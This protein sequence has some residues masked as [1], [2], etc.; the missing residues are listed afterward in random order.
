MTWWSLCAFNGVGSVD[1][2]ALLSPVLAPPLSAV[3]MS[4]EWHLVG[5]SAMD[6]KHYKTLQQT[7]D[8]IVF[9]Q[10]SFW[11]SNELLAVKRLC[12]ENVRVLGLQPTISDDPPPEEVL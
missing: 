8:E 5:Y 10:P 11:C 2:S 12:K 3:A 1:F 6:A 9:I 4:T 7:E